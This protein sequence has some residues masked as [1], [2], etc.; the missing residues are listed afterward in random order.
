MLRPGT[1]TAIAMGMLKVIIEEDLYDHD[2]VERWTYGFDELAERCRG[3]DL[4]ELSEMTWVPEEKIIAAARLFATSKPANIVWGLAVDMQSQGTPCAQSIAALWT[5]TG[6]LDVPGGVV[7]TAA[8]MG[9]D[10]PSAGA[11]GYYDIL[12]EEQQKKRIGWKEYPMYRYGL[13]QSMPDLC[14]EETEADRVK[15]LWLQTSNGISCMS[16]EVE[17]WYNALQK[18]EFCAA[19]DIFFTP[20]IEAYADIV[21][22][23]ATW[24]EKKGVRA[25]YYF[26]S[27][28]SGSVTPEGE[29]LSDAEINRRL[30]S[31]FDNDA[32]YLEKVSHARNPQP[33]WAMWDSDEALFDTMLEP[34]GYSWDE[35]RERGP[36]YQVYKYR[37]YETGD[38]RP[39]GEVGFNTPTGR[40]ELYCSLFSQFGYDPLPYIEEPGV[41]PKTTPKLFEEY[42][43]IMITGARTTSF[44]HSEHRQV[45]RLRQLTPD[46]W[47]QIHPKTAEANGISD[48]D[49][50]W[51]ENQVRVN[52][53]T[54]MEETSNPIQVD[55][56]DGEWEV[57]RCKQRAKVTYE[58]S[59]FEIAAQH[60]W[61]FPEQDGSEPN[62]FG[63]RQSFIN[64]LLKNKPGQTGFGA[65]LKCTL[66]KVYPCTA[67]E[68]LSLPKD[69]WQRF[70]PRE[71]N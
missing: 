12:T 40:V 15:G 63:L 24:A 29:V 14:L 65:D 41:G 5:I 56:G 21:L 18:V 33:A 66:A 23:V 35:L 19:V 71:A 67:E 20:T 62:L 34:S 53:R 16:C 10:P 54:V 2:F 70:D 13:T 27:A 1:D 52:S 47:V 39:D 50:V 32:E 22:P 61:W 37:K 49:W 59:E 57:R 4:A 44:F 55:L 68:V 6:N 25:H 42:P 43:L 11:W 60:G 31:R 30:G 7:Y 45:P 9:I 26:L 8:P 38:L 48:G 64:Q 46:P 28:I 3:L 17:R 36:A 51:I 69:R 58:V